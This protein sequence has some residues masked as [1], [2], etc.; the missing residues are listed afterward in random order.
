MKHD[1]DLVRALRRESGLSRRTIRRG[2]DDLISAGYLIRD[3]SG[4]VAVIKD[5]PPADQAEG[6]LISETLVAA[7]IVN[8]DRQ[9][10]QNEK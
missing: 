8:P 1:P 6:S 4:Y 2:L 5:E 9:G 7:P 3:A 10:G